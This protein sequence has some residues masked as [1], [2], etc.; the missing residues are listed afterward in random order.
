[1][2]MSS[3]NH[4]DICPR[5]RTVHPASPLVMLAIALLFGGHSAMFG[6]DPLALFG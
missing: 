2:M 6:A 5:G 3:R 1:M 4:P